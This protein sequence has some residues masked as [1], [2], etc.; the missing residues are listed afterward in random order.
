MCL[1][2]FCTLLFTVCFNVPIAVWILSLDEA[3][4]SLRLTVLPFLISPIAALLLYCSPRGTCFAGFMLALIV[5]SSLS[6]LVASGIFA[7]VAANSADTNTDL[8]KLGELVYGLISGFL[9]VSGLS[10]FMVVLSEWR[11]SRRPGD[12]RLGDDTELTSSRTI[13]GLLSG[14]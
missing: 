14:I 6:K 7:N 5:L 12:K 11:C 4:T 3:T 8:G 13:N 9:G 10:D 2:R 1:P